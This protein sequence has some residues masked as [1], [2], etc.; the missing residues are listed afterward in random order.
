MRW[1]QKEAAKHNMKIGLKNSLDIIADLAPIMDFA[2]NEQCAALSECGAY[3]PMLALN[4]PVFHIEYPNPLNAQA[5]NG[6]SCK[7][8]G[9]LGTDTILKDLKLNGLTY[10]CDGSFVDTPTIGGTSPPRP[11]QPSPRPSSTRPGVPSPSLT[12]SSTT[13]RLSK[14]SSTAR[15][16]TSTPGGGGG[17]RSK[18]WDQC[19]GNDWK[20]CTVCE[21]SEITRGFEDES[22]ANLG[23]WCRRRIRVRVCRRR[24]IINACRLHGRIVGKSRS[25]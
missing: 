7:G 6:V 8:L 22:E 5:A 12:R 25:S 4:K 15:P 17:C 23:I 9:V 16:P 19:G 13:L 20:G 3:A 21:V 18:H 2:V 10:Y 24:I 14:T 1:M 11:P